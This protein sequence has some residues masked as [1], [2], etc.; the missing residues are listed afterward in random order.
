M[1]EAE[2]LTIIKNTLTDSSYIGDDCAFLKDFGLYVT[3]DSLVE[4]VH[5]NL[6]YMTPFQLGIKAVTVNVSDLLT[7]VSMPMYITVGLSLPNTVDEKFVKHS[8]G[9]ITHHQLLPKALP[10][11]TITAS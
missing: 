1:K 10:S 2:I 7:A 5:F 11:S 3:Q 9:Y 6:S 8:G 4:G